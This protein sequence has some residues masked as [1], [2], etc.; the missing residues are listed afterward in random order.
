MY[1]QRKCSWKTMW[2]LCTRNLR[3]WSSRMQR[4]NL[5]IYME[6]SFNIFFCSN[7]A[8]DCD[9]IGAL[10]NFCNI[11]TG[12]CKCRANTYG[13]ECNQCRTGFWNFPNCQRCDC[14]GHADICDPKTGS[15][16]NC[17]DYTEGSTCDRCIEGFY[18][19]PR[20]N[21]DIPCRQCP[22]PGVSGSNHSFA[23]TCTLDPTRDVICHC[24]EGYA[25]KLYIFSYG[26]S[27]HSGFFG[28]QVQDVTF[29]SIIIT[30]I[31]K[32]QGVLAHLAIA[33]VK[34]IF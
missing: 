22:C 7:P 29:V 28:I 30:E 27:T 20:L 24:K 5:R 23:D 18:G 15:C 10:D 4:Y 17:R 19:D 2:H 6:Q 8:C 1:L 11:T 9:S 21:V 26:I 14:N 33:T 25:G 13:R 12:Q 32:C 3:F 34:S 31:L 16:I